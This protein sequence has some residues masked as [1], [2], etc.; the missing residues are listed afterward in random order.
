VNEKVSDLLATNRR[1]I[2]RCAL[3]I[4]RSIGTEFG[5]DVA[6][7]WIDGVASRGP[8]GELGGVL[9]IV[10]EIYDG[11]KSIAEDLDMA[12]REVIGIPASTTAQAAFSAVSDVDET[13]PANAI[14]RLTRITTQDRSTGEGR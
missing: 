2:D 9:E 7:Q 10:R 3:R 13:C 11:L 14:A 12:V 5:N 8:A 1:A 4:F 6:A